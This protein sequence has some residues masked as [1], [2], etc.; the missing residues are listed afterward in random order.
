MIHFQEFFELGN[1]R[2][3]FEIGRD[4]NIYTMEIGECYKSGLFYFFFQ[5]AGVYTFSSASLPADNS[6]GRQSPSQRWGAGTQNGELG[7]SR[8]LLVKVFRPSELRVP[9]FSRGDIETD[10]RNQ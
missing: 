4:D 3:L 1:A 9:Y 2:E 5:R 10:L 8:V 7:T 6:A